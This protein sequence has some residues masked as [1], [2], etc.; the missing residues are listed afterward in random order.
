[1]SSLVFVAAGASAGSNTGFTP[2]AQL[3]YASTGLVK[4]Y[5]P[6]A[7]VTGAPACAS[8]GNEYAFV[9][10]STTPAGKALL[11]GI[12]EAHPAGIPVWMFGSGTCDV[13]AGS[14]SV[15]SFFTLG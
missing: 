1:L 5:F 7:T 8:N 6:V 12:F 15:A 9:F 2:V 10:D 4:V 11:A 14:E 13:L 3:S